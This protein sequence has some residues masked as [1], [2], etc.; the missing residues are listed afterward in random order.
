MSNSV[1]KE[2]CAKL[3]AKYSIILSQQVCFV[4][5]LCRRSCRSARVSKFPLCLCLLASSSPRSDGWAP[6]PHT[7]TGFP[8]V[9]VRGS[10]RSDRIIVS[11]NL[12]KSAQFS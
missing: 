1:P 5:A 6:P 11:L 3:R 9:E 7:A 2:L 12:L 8:L 4:S 10:L